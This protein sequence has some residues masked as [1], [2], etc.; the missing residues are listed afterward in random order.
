MGKIHK[1]L[2]SLTPR[3]PVV[4]VSLCL[5]ITAITPPLYAAAASIAQ[6]YVTSDSNLATGMGASL[7]AD[8][9]TTSRV[10]ERATLS[11]K[12]KFVGIVT[13]KDSNLVTLTNATANVVVT[14]S[15]EANAFLTDLNGVVKKGDFLVISPLDGILMKANGNDTNV[16]GLN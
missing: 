9:T 2:R 11:N 7:G 3:L 6:G 16:V 1:L 13:T 12:G 8:G 4:L 10:V 15:G 14:T 5:M